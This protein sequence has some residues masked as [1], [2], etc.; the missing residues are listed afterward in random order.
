[1][2]LVYGSGSLTIDRK[3]ESLKIKYKGR[4]N[5]TQK[6]A[7]I[8]IAGSRKYLIIT[9]KDGKTFDDLIFEY[10]GKFIIE[11]AQSTISGTKKTVDLK[12]LGLDF[13]YT[14]ES[15]YLHDDGT[16]GDTLTNYQV[17]PPSQYNPT[18]FDEIYKVEEKQN[19][20]LKTEHSRYI[21]GG[22]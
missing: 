17:G 11:Y 6:G 8:N 15:N 7:M 3:V 20:Y 9:R 5:I 10:T 18:Q 13:W 14:D 21:K 19:K 1:M 2:T 12:A 4:I 16:W 22:Y